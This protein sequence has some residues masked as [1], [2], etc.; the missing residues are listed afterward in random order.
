MKKLVVLLIGLCLLVSC[1]YREGILQ[2]SDGSYLTFKGNLEGVVARVSDLEPFTLT[3]ENSK[4]YQ[5]PPGKHTI[6]LY[7]NGQLIVDR[8][9]FVQNQAT[10][11]VN[12]P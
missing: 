11:E 3:G 8:V 2:G 7:R 5:V 10:L 12:V 1:G 9:M 4:L 6:K